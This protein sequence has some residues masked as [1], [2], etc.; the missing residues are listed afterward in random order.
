MYMKVSRIESAPA[1]ASNMSLNEKLA[2]HAGRPTGFDYLRIILSI[3]IVCEHSIITSYGETAGGAVWQ[4]PFRPLVGMFLP[5]FFALSGFLVAGSLFRTASLV[6]FLGLR[7]IRIYPALC[8]EVLISA[9]LIGPLLTSLPL[10]DYFSSPVFYL[11]LLN[12]TGDIHYLLPGLFQNNPFPDTVNLQLWTVPFELGCYIT[13]SLLAVIG[14]KKFHW[15]APAATVLLLLA[16]FVVRVIV[17]KQ[18]ALIAIHGG[19]PGP[20]LIACFLSGVSL[21][22]YKEKLPWSRSLCAISGVL[23]ALLFGFIPLGDFIAAPVAAYFTVSLGVTNPKK[24]RILQ[25][26]DYSYG[27]YL[28]GFVLQQALASFPWAREWWINIL[29]CV[30]AAIGMA[31][32]SWHFIEKPALDLRRYFQSQSA[33][34]NEPGLEGLPAGKSPLPAAG[35]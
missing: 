29:F 20:L 3:A 34:H 10:K 21:Y 4:L 6:Q 16:Y 23:T 15:M 27:I 11:Y 13:L 22:L 33:K 19:L 31:A 25:G 30:P 14:I 5:M 1:R 35:A 26:A 28:Y 9:L 32:A 17:K 18:W 12:I 7:V 8:V 2:L 24:L